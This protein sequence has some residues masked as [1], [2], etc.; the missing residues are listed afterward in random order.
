LENTPRRGGWIKLKCLDTKE[1][2]S[3]KREERETP[4]GEPGFL[5]LG[6]NGDH[7]SLKVKVKLL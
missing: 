3:L 6:E 5:G 7:D 4:G 2:I 1:R